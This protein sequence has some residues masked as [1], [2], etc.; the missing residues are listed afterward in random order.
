MT[1][2]SSRALGRSPFSRR[3]PKS[4]RLTPPDSSLTPGDLVLQVKPHRRRQMGKI[5]DHMTLT[6]RR[7]DDG[8][9]RRIEPD[10]HPWVNEGR[11]PQE[12]NDGN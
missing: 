4:A 7:H 3:L 2:S 5:L 6:Q 9:N 10:S 1:S 12:D 8:F 11:H